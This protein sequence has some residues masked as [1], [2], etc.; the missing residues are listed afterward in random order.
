MST[1]H[2]CMDRLTVKSTCNNLRDSNKNGPNGEPLVCKLNKSLYGLKQAGRIWNGVLHDH[3]IQQNFKR[4]LIDPCL[5]LLNE[6]G[7]L[8]MAV[9]IYVDDITCMAASDRW[10]SFVTR[11][12][13]QFQTSDPVKISWILAS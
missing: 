12:Q 8:V 1:R 4:S 13:Q 7:E 2:T 6:G 9:A 11:L 3:L 5:Y 10:K